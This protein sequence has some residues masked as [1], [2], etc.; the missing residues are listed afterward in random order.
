MNLICTLKKITKYVGMKRRFYRVNLTP[1]TENTKN[2]PKCLLVS[3]PVSQSSLE[4][5]LIWTPI[6]EEEVSKLQL[7]PVEEYMGI[8]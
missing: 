1:P 6:I 3:L 2:H 7:H 8:F 5:S 4:N